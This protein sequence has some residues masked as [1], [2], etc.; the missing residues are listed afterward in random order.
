MTR[1]QN[2][3][4]RFNSIM[5]LVNH[6]WTSKILNIP[7]NTHPGPDLINNDKFVELKFAVTPNVKNYIKWTVLEWQVNYQNQNPDKKGFWGLGIYQLQ[8][9][10][11]EIKTENLEN[12]ENL[13]ISRELFIVEWDWINQFPPYH[14][15]GETKK[16]SWDHSLRHPKKNKL[17]K[18]IQTYEVNKGLIHLTQETQINYFQ[19][20][21]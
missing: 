7:I 21:K 4:R 1:R 10:P 14:N 8:T 19:H 2:K 12:L 11:S 6:A 17:P 15:S 9:P 20:L 13:V 5:P 16:S 3:A 18:T